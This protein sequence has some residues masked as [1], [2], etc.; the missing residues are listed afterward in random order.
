MG[1][2]AQIL[3]RVDAVAENCDAIGA[4]HMMYRLFTAHLDKCLELCVICSLP[5]KHI[6]QL[7]HIL[8]LKNLGELYNV[9]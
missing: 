6:I 3:M 4:Q 5:L 8:L 1:R 7:F 2:N 9:G